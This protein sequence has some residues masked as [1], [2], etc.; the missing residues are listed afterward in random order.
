MY[1]CKM[2]PTDSLGRWHVKCKV[3]KKKKRKQ[4]MMIVNVVVVANK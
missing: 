2:N 1:G 4:Q 3:N